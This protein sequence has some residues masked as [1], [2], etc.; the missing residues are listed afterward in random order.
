[1]AQ[2]WRNRRLAGTEADVVMLSGGAE[3]DADDEDVLIR[4]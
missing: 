3:P 1:M 2:L 4:R